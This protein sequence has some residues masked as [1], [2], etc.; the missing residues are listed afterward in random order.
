MPFDEPD[1]RV[2]EQRR[3]QPGHEVGLEV[4]DVGVEEAHEVAAGDVEG[5]PQ[6]VALPLTR[7]Q[8]GED[9]GDGVDEPARRPGGLGGPV[10]GAVVEDDDLVDEATRDQLAPD[11]GDDRADGAG[12]VAGRETDRHRL[13]QLGLPVDERR[14]LGCGGHRD[15]KRTGPRRYH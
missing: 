4:A 12:L 9:V 10:P 7:R 11:R 14:K 15:W 2:L 5:L 8:V 3:E 13:A 6:R 1:R